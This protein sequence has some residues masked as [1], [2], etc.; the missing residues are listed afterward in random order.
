MSQNSPYANHDRRRSIAERK[1]QL[2]QEGATFRAEMI[3]CRDVVRSSMSTRSWSKNLLGRAAG[4]AFS[5][6]KQPSAKAVGI[7]TLVP[8]L[9][10]GAS[11]LSKRS[12]KSLVIGSALLAAIGAA[13]Y[14]NVK[15]NKS[16]DNE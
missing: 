10:T 3:N 9:A 12:R 15:S 14:F 4:V 16:V 13:T 5:L 2:L 8:L 11:L 6:I 7:Q 1:L